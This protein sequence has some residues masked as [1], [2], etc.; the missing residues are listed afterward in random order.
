MQGTACVCAASSRFCARDSSS[1]CDSTGG[2]EWRASN[3]QQYCKTPSCLKVHKRIV[4]YQDHSVNA[5]QGS[6]HHVMRPI[7]KHIH[8]HTHTH[9]QIYISIYI[10]IYIYTH[11]STHT[12]THI[13]IY[14]GAQAPSGPRPSYCRGLTVTFRHTTAGRTP[15][16]EWSAQSRDVW[17]HTANTRERQPCPPVGFEH[18]IP[19]SKRP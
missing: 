10:H 3:W 1:F 2:G 19:G 9:T 13:Y 4:L 15:L 16:D 5:V 8:T 12:H 11:T 6:K 7:E 17:Q 18:T 14:N